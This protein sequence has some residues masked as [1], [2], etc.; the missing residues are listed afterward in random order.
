[1]LYT[2]CCPRYAV[3]CM[4]CVV[5][6]VMYALCC[7]CMVH[8][9]CCMLYAVCCVLHAVCCVPCVVCCIICA[10][11]CVLCDVCCFYIL[12]LYAACCVLYAVSVCCAHLSSIRHNVLH[13]QLVGCCA[14]VDEVPIIVNVRT[15]L[16]TQSYNG[17]N[18]CYC[19]C[20]HYVCSQL[21]PPQQPQPTATLKQPTAALTQLTVAPK[22]PT[23]ALTQL[24]AGWWIQMYVLVDSSPGLRGYGEDANSELVTMCGRCHSLHHSVL[25]CQSCLYFCR[26]GLQDR[27]T[28]EASD[29]GLRRAAH[30]ES[31]QNKKCCCTLGHCCWWL[32]VHWILVFRVPR[33]LDI[34][35]FEEM[36]IYS[37]MG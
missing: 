12:F 10:V 11:C 8:A 9:I 34:A 6:C 23:A 35:L 37:L 36:S 3:Y 19:Y 22:Q 25:H 24:T 32:S 31:I 17:L 13:T 21:P 28:K 5:C 16:V 15:G 1:M 33:T 26:I 27:D 29:G 7:I 18:E 14:G 30:S 20:Y 2:T 4:L